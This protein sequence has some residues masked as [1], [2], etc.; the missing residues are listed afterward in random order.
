MNSLNFDEKTF[1][2]LSF[3]S[4]GHGSQLR[5]NTEPLLRKKEY[6]MNKISKRYLSIAGAMILVGGVA[7]LSTNSFA[8]GNTAPDPVIAPTIDTAIAPTVSSTPTFTP[9]IID[10]SN[11]AEVDDATEAPSVIGSTDATEVDTDSD[12]PSIAGST[13][14]TQGED[15]SDVSGLSVSV[16]TSENTEESDSQDAPSVNISTNTSETSDTADSGN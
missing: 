2:Y 11:V 7:V 6:H 16:D 8:S 13:D 3:T 10:P 12:A 1:I 9:S 14:V 15:N 4:Q 5:F